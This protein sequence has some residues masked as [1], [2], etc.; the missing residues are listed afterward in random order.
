MNKRQAKKHIKKAWRK[1][2]QV[3]LV[4]EPIIYQSSLE[5]YDIKNTIRISREDC[6]FCMPTLLAE[7]IRFVLK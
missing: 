4:A 5:Q 1:F 3:K 6:K 2:H 7:D